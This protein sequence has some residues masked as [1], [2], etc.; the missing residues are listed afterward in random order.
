MREKI[1]RPCASVP[2]GNSHDGGSSAFIRLA[3]ITG[4]V[5]AIQGASTAT[6][7]AIVTRLPPTQVL[8]PH[9][10]ASAVA[11]ARVDHDVGEIDQRVDEQ[12]EQHDHQ[13]A[14]LDSRDIALEHRVDQERA[15]AR[16][17]EQLLH[18]YR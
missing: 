7:M 8:E 5:S 16:P 15:D 10:I 6:P 1:S 13:D 12:E 14:A 11:D 3:S 17:R 9:F 18:H 2:N 4:S